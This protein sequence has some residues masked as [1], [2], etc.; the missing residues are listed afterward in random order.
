MMQKTT[1]YLPAELKAALERVAAE[2]QRTESDIIREGLRLVLRQSHP[3]PRSGIFDSG[4]P[5]L[6][7]R[8]DELLSDGFGRL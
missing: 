6:S 4:E 3:S 2:M 8:V 5:D 7:E 1:I